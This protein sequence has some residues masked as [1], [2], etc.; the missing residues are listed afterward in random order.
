MWRVVEQLDLAAFTAEA[1]ALEGACGR[2][3]KSVRLLL[4]LWLYAISV[5]VASAR[6]IARLTET[7]AAFRWLVGDQR[8]S[9][10]T[11]S[12]FRVEHGAALEQLFTDVLG[13]LL[14]EQLV[15]LDLV[16]QDGLASEPAHRHPRSAVKRPCKSAV[17]R[18]RCISRPCLRSRM[19]RSDG[20]REASSLGGGSEVSAVGR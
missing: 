18:P 10:T 17:S 15:T 1:K 16:A 7:E 9:H 3:W 20:S 12:A 13:A 6:K 2:P 5:G 14:H 11:L 19:I 4:A 8:V